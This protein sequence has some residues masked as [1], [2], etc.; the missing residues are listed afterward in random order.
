MS[1]QGGDDAS[2]RVGAQAASPYATGRGGIRLRR[3][4]NRPDL[5]EQLRKAA[6]I[7]SDACRDK[8]ADADKVAV[9]SVIRSR[10]LRA[11]F[12]SR[13]SSDDQSV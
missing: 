13:S 3:Y 6:A 7:L 5:L 11:R 8:G 2:H 10:W 1:E 9:E 12:S 4:W